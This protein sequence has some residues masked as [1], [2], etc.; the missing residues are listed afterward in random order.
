MAK[1]SRERRAAAD[2]KFKILLRFTEDINNNVSIGSL[3]ERYKKVLL[4]DLKIGKLLLFNFTSSWEVIFIHGYTTDIIENIDIAEDFLPHKNFTTVPAY[5]QEK[6]GGTDILIPVIHKGQAIAFLL[7]GDIDDDQFKMSQ[8]VKHMNFV[9]TLTNIILVAIENKRLFEENL[10]QE[11]LKKELEL[12]S[13][14]QSMLIPSEKSYPQTVK[15]SFSTYY[16]PHHEVGGDYYD[17]IQLNDS[18]IGFCIADVSGKGIAAALVMSNFQANLR[19]LFTDNISLVDL[20]IKL[21][22]IVNEN[23]KGEK[24][25]TLFIGKYNTSTQILNYINAAHIPPLLYNKNSGKLKHLEKGCIGMGM[26]DELTQINEGKIKILPNSKLLSFTDG[27]TE[28]KFQ[29]QET[30]GSIEVEKFIKNNDRIDNNLKDLKKAIKT[31]LKKDMI[32]DDISII[33]IEFY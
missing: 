18:E 15:M 26:L 17:F 5:G 14:M 4:E 8:A 25:L 32:F 27:L 33:G 10:R 22:R 21:N 16:L 31:Y 3:F 13:K 11:A 6:E 19:A 12:A 9:H 1:T 23:A 30:D 24:Y 7:M 2:Q 28:F 29:P 20:V